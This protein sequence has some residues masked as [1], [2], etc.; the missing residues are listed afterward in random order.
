M[1]PNVKTAMLSEVCA[2]RQ[3]RWWRCTQEIV[4]SVWRRLTAS[5]ITHFLQRKQPKTTNW[6]YR[7]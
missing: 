4:N 6:Y 1:S 7:N 3:W 2:T 5:G